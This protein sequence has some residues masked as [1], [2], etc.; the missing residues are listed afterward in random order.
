MRLRIRDRDAAQVGLNAV[1]ES[2]SPMWRIMS[3]TAGC[4]ETTPTPTDALAETLAHALHRH[5]PD[6]PGIFDE[7]L[8]AIVRDVLAKHPTLLASD[9]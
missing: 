2:A 6:W 9:C 3:A 4:T 1:A 5:L 7:Q 8:S